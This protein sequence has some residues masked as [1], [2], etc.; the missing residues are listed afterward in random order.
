VS[1]LRSPN[2]FAADGVAVSVV[3][4]GSKRLWAGVPTAQTSEQTVRWLHPPFGSWSSSSQFDPVA[5]SSTQALSRGEELADGYSL[6]R[7]STGA[8]VP[9]ISLGGG[10]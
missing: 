6:R 2:A 8:R 1:R 10:A 9:L 4:T 3:L 5:N 7:I